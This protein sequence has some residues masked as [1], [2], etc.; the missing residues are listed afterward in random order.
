MNNLNNLRWVDMPLELINQVEVECV[1]LIYLF[2][3]NG[4]IVLNTSDIINATTTW[5]I[6][7]IFKTETN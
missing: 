2:I 1:K 6:I 7:A 3:A 4:K 5:A